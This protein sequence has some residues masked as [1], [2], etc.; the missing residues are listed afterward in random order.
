MEW[1]SNWSLGVSKNVA[2]KFYRTP[3]FQWYNSIPG[4]I[5]EKTIF[6]NTLFGREPGT[7]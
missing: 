4:L 5:R 6:K 3:I 1:Y 7:E 2:L